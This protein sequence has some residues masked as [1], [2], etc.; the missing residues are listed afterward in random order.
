MLASPQV[1][2]SMQIRANL[3]ERAQHSSVGAV[4]FLDGYD[5]KGRPCTPPLYDPKLYIG[6]AI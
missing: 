3:R 5:T 4:A 2:G 1:N 6:L